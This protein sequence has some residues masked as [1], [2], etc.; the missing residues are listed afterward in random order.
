[1]R[2]PQFKKLTTF[3]GSKTGKALHSDNLRRSGLNRGIESNMVSLLR[4]LPKP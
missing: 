2:K 1:M 4:A 3:W